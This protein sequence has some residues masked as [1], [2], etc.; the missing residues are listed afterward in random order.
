MMDDSYLFYGGPWHN[1]IVAVPAGR[2]TYDI[3]SYKR[4]R[5]TAASISFDDNNP[6]NNHIKVNT[7]W[8]LRCRFV[9]WDIES[10]VE[11]WVYVY[12]KPG[13]LKPRYD[14]EKVARMCL[15]RGLTPIVV[16]W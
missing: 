1:K 12:T 15:R 3:F 13:E 2:G 6:I 10:T 14:Q 5:F 4:P 16:P 7:Y 11:F 9:D 8:K